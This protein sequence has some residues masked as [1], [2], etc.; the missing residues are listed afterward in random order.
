M[1]WIALKIAGILLI[2]MFWYFYYGIECYINGLVS[3]N[4][5]TLPFAG[6]AQD[7][8]WIFLNPSRRPEGIPVLYLLFVHSWLITPV[9]LAVI[10]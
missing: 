9:I 4:S 3:P 1:T 10:Y 8:D 6:L 5:V 2:W 7:I